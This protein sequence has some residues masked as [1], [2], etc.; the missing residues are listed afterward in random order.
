MFEQALEQELKTIAALNNRVYPLYSSED[1]KSPY[2]IYASS[3][4]LRTKTM[5]GYQPG[6]K[7]SGELN[8]IAPRYEQ[9]KMITAQVIEL[10]IGMTGRSIGTSGPFIQELIYDTPVELYEP[11]PKLYRCVIDFEVYF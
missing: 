4:G 1:I 11:Q 10:I 5:D 7:V 3:E 8:V 6:K 9:M 2:L